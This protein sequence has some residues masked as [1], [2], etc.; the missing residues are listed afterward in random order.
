MTTAFEFSVTGVDDVKRKLQQFPPKIAEKV[1][2]QALRQGANHMLKQIRANAPVKTGR[3][4]KAIKVKNSRINR[5]N[6]N[7]VVGVYI[8]INLGKSRKDPSGAW[9]GPFVDRGYNHR[10]KLL[11]GSQAVAAGVIT[12]SDYYAKRAALRA[13][14]TG[15]YAQGVRVRSGGKGVPGQ[16]FI[17]RGFEQTKA[18]AGQLI[19]DAS[20]ALV[21]KAVADL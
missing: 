9:Y 17:R 6:K 19:V 16:F 10:S 4:K 2:R 14:R 8:N 12:R 11:T 15:R 7:G 18:T 21:D 13:K 20:K 1:L 3:L 5:L